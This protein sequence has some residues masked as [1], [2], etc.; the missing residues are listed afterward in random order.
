MII[1]GHPRTGAPSR[2]AD[3]LVQ[4]LGAQDAIH[5]EGFVNAAHAQAPPSSTIS[6]P[7]T[8]PSATRAPSKQVCAPGLVSVHRF[9]SQAG[10]RHP[11]LHR[12]PHG[13]RSADV[14][15]LLMFLSAPALSWRAANS[16]SASSWV[17]CM[18]GVLWRCCPGFPS[19]FITLEEVGARPLLQ[20]LLS[21]TRPMDAM[22]LSWDLPGVGGVPH[23]G[24]RW[25]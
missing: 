14:P 22:K 18:C 10:P 15:V 20:P 1:L 24:T 2:G 8:P 23:M 17:T 4:A 5:C 6:C 12:V 16:R 19:S 13:S 11:H 25:G 9:R 3:L 21:E 7:S